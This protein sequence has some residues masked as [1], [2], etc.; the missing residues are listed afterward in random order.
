VNLEGVRNLRGLPQ[1]RRVNY[2]KLLLICGP[3]VVATG[4]FVLFFRYVAPTEPKKQVVRVEKQTISL[5]VPT[6]TG[7][8]REMVVENGN[9]ATPKERA[10]RIIEELK[11]SGLLPRPL[12]LRE[13]LIDNDG[14][15]YLNF[16]K[17]LRLGSEWQGDEIAAVYSI[18]N[19]FLGSFRY[20]KKVQLLIDWQP[21]YTLRGVVYTYLP[22]E[23]NKQVM[24]D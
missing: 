15:V 3:L 20:T 2:K 18:V 1:K 19:S 14:V 6:D 21:V 23:F 10:D 8:L 5:Y 16:S 24:E 7:K 4:L 12:S 13:M 11:N 22:M 17:D 9:S